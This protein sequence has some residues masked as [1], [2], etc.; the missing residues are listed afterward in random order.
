LYLTSCRK[1]SLSPTK[2]SNPQSWLF[3]GTQ[4]RLWCLRV[5][6]RLQQ[7][8]CATPTP[9][10]GG[11]W[12]WGSCGFLQPNA[13]LAQSMSGPSPVV[14][15]HFNP[16]SPIPSPQF[17]NP[18]SPCSPISPS[19]C[20]QLPDPPTPSPSTIF[21]CVLL[22]LIFPLSLSCPRTPPPVKCLCPCSWA[23]FWF[24]WPMFTAT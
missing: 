2:P 21:T 15:H 22:S 14:G 18:P 13:Y 3:H 17:S 19:P 24:L 8:P 23:P 5:W 11:G 4:Q 9:E 7:G 10:R 12:W 6:A 16:Q 20:P 1:D